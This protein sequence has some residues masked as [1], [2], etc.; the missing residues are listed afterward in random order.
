MGDKQI[1]MLKDKVTDFRRYA[2]ILLSLSIFLFIGLLIPSE[3]TVTSGPE[4]SFIILAVLSMLVFALFFHK[5]ATS[6]QR[7]LNE[8]MQ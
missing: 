4:P 3:G 8:E 2:Y 7:Q 5:R 6:C 1:Q